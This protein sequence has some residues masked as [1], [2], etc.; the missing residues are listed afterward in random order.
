[1]RKGW[2]IALT[3]ILAVGLVLRWYNLGSR[4][5]WLDE[6]YTQ[7]VS[8]LPAS[9][10]IQEMRVDYSPPLYFLIT[11]YWT[12]LWGDSEFALRSWS[13][14]CASLSLLVVAAIAWR[15]TANRNTVLFAVGIFACAEIQVEWARTARTYATAAFLFALAIW[16]LI[17]YLERDRRIWLFLHALAAAA[18]VYQHNVM[19]FYLAALN[20]G[21]LL[22]PGKLNFRRRILAAIITDLIV[23]LC[24]APWIPGFLQ[25]LHALN[26]A[27]F[28]NPPIFHDF[29]RVVVLQCGVQLDRLRDLSANYLHIQDSM[30]RN[31]RL[32][33]LGIAFVLILIACTPREPRQRRVMLTLLVLALFPLLLA[34]FYSRMRTSVWVEKTFIPSSAIFPIILAGALAAGRSLTINALGSAALA[35]VLLASGLTSVH[36]IRQGWYEDWRSATAMIAPYATPDTAVVFVSAEGE[37]LYR[38]YCRRQDFS[39]ATTTGVPTGFFTHQPPLTMMRLTSQQ[40]LD[41][42]LQFLPAHHIRRIVLV[43]SYTS[44]ADPRQITQ[45]QL[46][47]NWHLVASGDYG[48][49]TV[50]IYDPGP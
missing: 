26:R 31:Y 44:W 39:P 42:F 17:E 20:L 27:Y 33:F 43:Q 34:F 36:F 24:F 1:M 4:S 35:L 30:Q 45:G 13:A 18:L 25:Q 46:D 15:A 37:N 40:E 49:V 11:H 32:L 9:D 23:I 2:L 22:W 3:V 19:W 38:Y 14:L 50:R 48:K 6:G 5:L 21:G 10:L 16:L 28:T 29:S 12:C 47:A 41:P 7:W 8:T